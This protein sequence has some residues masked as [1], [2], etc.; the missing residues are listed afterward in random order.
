[1]SDDFSIVNDIERHL[2]Q[3]VT[4]Y[5]ASGGQSGLG[6]TGVLVKV[7]GNFVRLI[8]QIGP[9]PGCA[10]GSCCNPYIDNVYGDS[11]KDDCYEDGG[12][13]K[14][15]KGFEGK[16]IKEVKESKECNEDVANIAMNYG[17][18]GKGEVGQVASC[19]PNTLGSIVDLPIDRIV[20]FVHNA[21]GSDW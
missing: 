12:K 19:C 16:E 15:R 13:K 9:A 11:E 3:T 5:T 8:T 6:F 20:A 21:V 10:L 17:E 1:M 2:G 7:S 4:I 18:E 14:K